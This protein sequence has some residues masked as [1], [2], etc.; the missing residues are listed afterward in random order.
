MYD[1][2]HHHSCVT[3]EEPAHTQTHTCKH[4]LSHLCTDST[5]DTCAN[6]R[7]AFEGTRWHLRNTETR[8]AVKYE[9]WQWQKKEIVWNEGFGE[10]DERDR[11]EQTCY[12]V[13][14]SFKGFH[15]LLGVKIALRHLYTKL[16][17]FLIYPSTAIF[18]LSVPVLPACPSFLSSVVFISLSILSHIAKRPSGALQS[19]F[20]PRECNQFPSNLFSSPFTVYIR[21]MFLCLLHCVFVHMHVQYVCNVLWSPKTAVLAFRAQ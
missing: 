13:H 20:V 6:G 15:S 7:C 17:F 8:E 1:T 12:N 10:T 18:S 3:V 9:W 19:S 14:W 21:C 16:F 11:G 5:E 4:S 2:A